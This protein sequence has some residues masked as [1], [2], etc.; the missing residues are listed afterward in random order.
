[1]G[2]FFW[3]FCSIL[4]VAL[5][6]LLFPFSVRIEFEAGERG[7]RAFFFFFKKKVYEYEKKWGKE[8]V[9]C[10][11]S[12]VGSRKDEV[13]GDESG[14]ALDDRRKTIDD[15]AGDVA[16]SRTECHPE[17]N[18]VKSKDLERLE[19]RDDRAEDGSHELSSWSE[20]QANDRIHRTPE[21]EEKEETAAVAKR[22]TE[23]PVTEKMESPAGNEVGSRKSEVGS[24][25]RE[26]G[27]DSADTKTE[28]HPER[29][30]VKSKDLAKSS[31]VIEVSSEAKTKKSENS[32]AEKPSGQASETKAKKPKLTDREFW[33]I[34]LTPDL[35]ARA[36]K[37]V[38]KIIAAVFS[39]FRIRFSDCFVE[40]IRSDYV[41]MGYIAAVNGVMKAYPYVGAWDLRMDWYHEKELRAA[42]NVRLS[43]TLLRIFCFVLETLVLAGILA[44]IFWRRRAH[45]LKTKELPEIGFI[46]KKIVD[47]IL[48]D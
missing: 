26:G 22:P 45:V 2:F 13:G 8:Q 47:F 18:E 15:R 5:V 33:T 43:I 12:E 32:D 40:G 20:P 35:D 19:T 28:C 30:E 21:A 27:G 29:N 31:S 17:R 1:M 37:Y 4:V 10:R 34:I 7:A 39:L 11:K 44:F 42:G 25:A 41:T 38:L 24:E 23:T 36:F 16:D 3:F 6:L 48:E 14:T 9:G 46:R